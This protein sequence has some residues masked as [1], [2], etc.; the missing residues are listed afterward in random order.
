MSLM[1]FVYKIINTK[2]NLGFYLTCFL[3]LQG[4]W[5]Q[6]QFCNMSVEEE[7]IKSVRAYDHCKAI[8]DSALRGSLFN[9]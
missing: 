1:N 4:C 2:F 3:F 9:S 7:Y 6:E 5:F 8:N